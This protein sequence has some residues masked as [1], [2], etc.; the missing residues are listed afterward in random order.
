MFLHD[1]EHR[2]LRTT[3]SL[4]ACTLKRPESNDLVSTTRSDDLASFIGYDS[5]NGFIVDS[6]EDTLAVA[7]TDLPNSDGFV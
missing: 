7:C 2:A 4:H 1:V 6:L 3:I 5:R